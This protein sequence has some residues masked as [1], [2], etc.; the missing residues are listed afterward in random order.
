MA[1][2]REQVS[3]QEMS[4]WVLLAVVVLVGVGLYFGL[5]RNAPSLV[6]AP[7]LEAGP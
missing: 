4:R 1:D 6:T 3:L 7:S 2:E 5:G